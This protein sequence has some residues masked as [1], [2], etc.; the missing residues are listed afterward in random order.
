MSLI[1]LSENVRKS[2]LLLYA[3]TAV[4][5]LLWIYVF[6]CRNNTG[7]AFFLL[8]AISIAA[9]LLYSDSYLTNRKAAYLLIPLLLWLCF[10]I[11]LNYEIAF[12]N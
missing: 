1:N 6:F 7:G 5:N 10:V 4:L 12:L 8:I 2:T 11:Y 3:L 9:A